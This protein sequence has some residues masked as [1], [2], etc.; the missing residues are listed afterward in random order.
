MIG[1]V[2]KTTGSYYWV[3][4]ERGETKQCRLKGNLRLR[5]YK[6][7]NPVVVGDRVKYTAD[8][9]ECMIE[10]IEERSNYIVRRSVK[11]SKQI[12]II[13]ANI[14]QA[15]LMITLSDPKTYLEFVDRYLVTAGAY[16][17]PAVL[18]F[19]KVPSFCQL[20]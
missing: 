16:H 1:T 10:D 14:D 15:I 20:Y 9:D 6:I 5:D 17:I 12:H 8:G 11:L 2:I 19:N 7:T 4:D 3:L 13:A 18:L